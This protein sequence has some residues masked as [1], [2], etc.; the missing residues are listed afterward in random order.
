M[1]EFDELFSFT[2]LGTV[3]TIMI[4][5]FWASYKFAFNLNM[6]GESIP[7]LSCSG[8]FCLSV[9]LFIMVPASSTNEI[10]KKT[11]SVLRSLSDDMPSPDKEKKFELKRCLMQDNNLTLWDIYVLNRSLIVASFGALLTY[12]I[13]I[14]TLGK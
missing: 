14:A 4:G 12:G 5:L 2:A 9:V 8:V 3:V 10:A 6:N 13:L 11:K 1:R 7:L